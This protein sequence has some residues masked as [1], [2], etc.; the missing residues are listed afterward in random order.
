ML[1]VA[2]ALDYQTHAAVTKTDL[3]RRGGVYLVNTMLAGAYI[4]IGVVIMAT[5]GGPL[6]DAGSGLTPL[7][8]GLVFGI[9]LSIVVVAGGE[10]A[11]SGMMVFTQG[12][13]RGTIS[14]ARAGATLLA[15][16]AGNLIGAIVF[17]AILHFSGALGP[18]TAGGRMIASMIEHK[19]GETSSQLFFRG[20]LCN[21]MVC[22]AIWCAGRLQN[23]VAKI[24][25]IFAC[26]LVFIT[27]GFEH[28]VANMTTF[29]F[30]LMGD[31]PH[32]TIGEFARNVLFVGLGNLVGGGLLVGAAN[33]VAA[34]PARAE[35]AADAPHGTSSTLAR[36]SAEAQPT[37]AAH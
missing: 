4:G 35:A 22:L 30:A 28:V 6:A 20:V 34:G 26:V 25:M 32:A 14:W 10:L 12:A 13:M 24:L 7:V 16:L 9:A 17:A 31:L 15:C 3:A 23:E 18:E 27:S 2:E 37:V 33:V 5:A 21:L 1:T 29:S 8:Q 19:A 11:T 36:S